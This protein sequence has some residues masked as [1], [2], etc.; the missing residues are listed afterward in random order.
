[1][2]LPVRLSLCTCVGMS[3]LCAAHAFMNY[4]TRFFCYIHEH[5]ICLNFSTEGISILII[6][7]KNET[8][9][10]ALKG[11]LGEDG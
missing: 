11:V 10:K 5:C 7:D 8:G 9:K 3:G 6:I 4:V 2:Y 1:M